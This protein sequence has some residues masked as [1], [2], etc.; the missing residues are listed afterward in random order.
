MNEDSTK[1]LTEDLPSAEPAVPDTMDGKLDWLIGEMRLMRTDLNE[2]KR[3]LT[4]L[5]QKV[6][7]R[8]YDTRPIWQAVQAQLGKLTVD[9]DKLTFKVEDQGH[10]M[11]QGLRRIE[12][13]MELLNKTFFERQTDQD[14]LLERVEKLE[15][16]LA[17]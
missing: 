9:V 7:A 16:R 17:S 3:R 15:E 4:T 5:E 10:E 13:K 14:E 8:L 12:R 2:V 6:E 11:K 1:D